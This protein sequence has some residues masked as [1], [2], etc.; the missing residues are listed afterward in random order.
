MYSVCKLLWI[1]N[2]SMYSSVV[3]IRS[4]QTEFFFRTDRV[5]LV[6]SSSRW[7]TLW[8]PK[9]KSLAIHWSQENFD[10][11]IEKGDIHACTCMLRNWN[12]TSVTETGLRGRG[13][14]VKFIWWRSHEMQLISNCRGAPPCRLYSIA[15]LVFRF[16][17][18]PLGVHLGQ[19]CYAGPKHEKNTI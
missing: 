1:K 10:F 6:G 16:F 7:S 5:R 18:L 13:G 17:F 3:L 8:M 14:G 19:V 12:W 4:D 11:Q 9:P 2:Y 15:H